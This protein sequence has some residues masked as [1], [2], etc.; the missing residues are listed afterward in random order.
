[1]LLFNHF[2]G[3]H[4]VSVFVFTNKLYN[5]R[6]ALN[7]YH[8]KTRSAIPPTNCSSSSSLWPVLSRSNVNPPLQSQPKSQLGFCFCYRV[9]WVTSSLD[10]K[11]YSFVLKILDTHH[12]IHR[13]SPGKWRICF[14]FM[15]RYLE[16]L[17][18]DKFSLKSETLRQP[19][20]IIIK[21]HTN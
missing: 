6:S 2:V 9:K 13:N 5:L 19:H 3:S 12:M 8:D 7:P 11:G 1:M 16:T 15:H 10:L 17:R 14:L 4:V 18:I 21:T 20:S